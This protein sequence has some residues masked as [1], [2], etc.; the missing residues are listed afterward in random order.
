MIFARLRRCVAN[1]HDAPRPLSRRCSLFRS[2]R[3]DLAPL[4]QNCTR[5]CCLAG[6]AAT[7]PFA[8][9]RRCV[10][11]GHD[12]PRPL[13]RRCSLFRSGRSDLAPLGQNCMRSCCLAGAAAT[14][15]FARLRRCVANG[16]CS[17]TALTPVFDVSVGSLRSRSARTE[18]HALVLLAGAA[19]T[20]PFAR[21]RRCVAND[22]IHD[23]I[24]PSSQA[25]SCGGRSSRESETQL[26]E[27]SETEATRSEGRTKA[28]GSIRL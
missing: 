13:S 14:L 18:L 1:G 6:A 10:A 24:Q 23:H 9:L 27:R 20:L 19:A 12:A 22:P 3:S 16:R 4:G 7:L 21:L 2:G 5:S 17:S 8:R 25:S 11:N 28:N 15:P 26:I